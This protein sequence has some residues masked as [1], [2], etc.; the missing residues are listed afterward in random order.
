L[1]PAWATAPVAAGNTALRGARMLLLAP[2]RRAAIL[3]RLACVQ[4]VELSSA[5]RF[6]DLFVEFMRL[7]A[8]TS[9]SRP[10]R[11]A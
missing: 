11:G 10:L 5:P 6:Q 2:S 3:E 1:L 9:T 4:H 7:G 8:A